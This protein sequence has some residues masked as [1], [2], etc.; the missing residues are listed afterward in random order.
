MAGKLSKHTLNKHQDKI[1]LQLSGLLLAVFR[2]KTCSNY[3]M[4]Q[5]IIGII[6]EVRIQ[7]T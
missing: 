7:V 5:N 1:A 4:V 2:S 6:I 3:H